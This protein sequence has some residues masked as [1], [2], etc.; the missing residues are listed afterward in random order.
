MHPS[1]QNPDADAD[2]DDLEDA[3][4]ALFTRHGAGLVA[5]AARLTGDEGS[6]R[7]I[8]Q[9]VLVRGAWHRALW[10]RDAELP[11]TW[12]FAQV[13]E[14]VCGQAFAAAGAP[15]AA[16]GVL[17]ASI[18][19]MRAVEA[20]TPEH[21]AVLLELYYRRRSVREAAEALGLVVSVVKARNHAAMRVL[22]AS[23]AERWP[24]LTAGPSA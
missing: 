11:R 7:E 12:L 21:R 4:R 5:Y 24:A 6:A 20:L 1:G 14:L 23:L 13:C 10:G 22:R 17:V 16:P 3:V 9:E 19:A 18:A 15:A 8:A 2:S